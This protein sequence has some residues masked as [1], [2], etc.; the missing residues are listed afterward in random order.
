M[1]GALKSYR[2][3]FLLAGC[4]LIICAFIMLL[5]HRVKDQDVESDESD[6]SVGS[7]N[8]SIKRKSSSK[9]DVNGNQNIQPATSYGV[10]AISP[11]NLKG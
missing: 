7:A 5:I 2:I 10:Q 4:P 9:P 11:N 6:G 8:N 3:P 1:Y